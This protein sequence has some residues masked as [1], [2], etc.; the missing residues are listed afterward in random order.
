MVKKWYRSKRVWLITVIAVCITLSLA[1]DLLL[2]RTLKVYVTKALTEQGWRIEKVDLDKQYITLEGLSKEGCFIAKAEIDCHLSLIPF[3]IDP[4]IVF[5]G[6]SIVLQEEADTGFNQMGFILGE[7]IWQPRVWIQ[8]SKIQTAYAECGFEF[9]PGEKKHSI[10]SLFLQEEGQEKPFLQADLHRYDKEITAQLQISEGKLSFL[11]PWIYSF[12]G[13]WELCTGEVSAY[14]Q[15]TWNL[16]SGLSSLQANMSLSHVHLHRTW[17]ECDIQAKMLEGTLS[18]SKQ[19]GVPLWRQADLFITFEEMACTRKDKLGLI[20]GLGEIRLH[21]KEDPYLKVGGTFLTAE[22]YIPFEFE[23]SGELLT[24][25]SYWLQTNL[26]LFLAKGTSQCAS[27]FWQDEQGTATLEVQC[28]KVGKEVS[29]LYQELRHYVNGPQWNIEKGDIEGKILCTFNPSGVTKIEFSDCSAKNI[30]FFMADIDA[31]L[32]A[33]N[34]Q[35]KGLIE[36]VKVSSLQAKV[37][38][39][40]FRY[41]EEELLDL[42][43]QVEIVEGQFMASYLEGLYKEAK[44]AAQVLGAPAENVLHIEC[45]LQGDD[46][47]KW[48]SLEQVNLS[49][50]AP[51]FVVADLYPRE[52]KTD[53]TATI[54]LPTFEDTI[55]DIDV[56]GVFTKKLTRKVED[57]FGSWDFSSIEGQFQMEQ[58][59]SKTVFSLLPAYKLSSPFEASCEVKGLFSPKEVVFNLCALEFSMNYGSYKLLGQMGDREPIT[60][61]YQRGHKHL[62]GKGFIDTLLCQDRSLGIE[63]EIVET[64]FYVA[65]G[66]LW[67]KECLALVEG[68]PV[69]TAFSCDK[70]SFTLYTNAMEI[71]L[72][73]LSPLVEKLYVGIRDLPLEG[74]VFI[75]ERGASLR[76]YKEGDNWKPYWTLAADLFEGSSILG[77]AGN[78][79]EVQAKL[80]FG[81]DQ[82]L[83]LQKI[84]GRY[85]SGGFSC[86]LVLDDIVYSNVDPISIVLK[87]VEGTREA[88]AVVGSITKQNEGFLLKMDPKTHVLGISCQMEPIKLSPSMDIYPINFSCSYHFE[89]LPA[90]LAFVKN[91]G[92]SAPECPKD[93]LSGEAYLR[94]KYDGKRSYLQLESPAFSYEGTNVG[95]LDCQLMHE[96]G[97]WKVYPSQI[98]PYKCS[99][100][101]KQKE[102]QWVVSALSLDLPAGRASAEGKYD[103]KLRKV[104]FPTISFLCTAQGV[105]VA[106]KGGI[107]ALL[108]EEGKLTAEGSL[109]RITAQRNNYCCSAR[110]G[111]KFQFS[112][113]E[114]LYL[115]KSQWTVSDL[116]SKK[117]IAQAT[118]GSLRYKLSDNKVL[119]EEGQIKLSKGVFPM[120]DKEIQL[121]LDAILSSDYKK[122]AAVVKEGKIDP[123]A[124]A[125]D[126]KQVQFLQEKNKLYL[127][128]SGL[129]ETKPI[130]IQW[131]SDTDFCNATV[132]CKEDPQSSGL[133]FRMPKFGQIQEV[134]GSCYGLALKIQKAGVSDKKLDTYNVQCKVDF[135][136]LAPLLPMQMKEMIKKWK[137]GSGYEFSGVVA[138]QAGSLQWNGAKG[139]ITGKEFVCLGRKMDSFS[140]KLS[141]TK[142]VAMLQDL[143]MEDD[144]GCVI[145][146][147]LEARAHPE[148][149]HWRVSAPLIHIKD[150]SPSLL[151]KGVK[152]GPVIKNISVYGLKGLLHDVNSF[153]G[154]G[155]LNFVTTG[156]K[157]EVSFWDIPLN[158]MKDFGLDTSILTPTV[159]EADFILSQG[160]CYFTCLKNMFSEGERSQFDLANPSQDA[161][162]SL[163]GTWHVDLKM[164]QNV[165]W[166]VTEDLILSIRGSLEKPKY[167][168][169][170]RKDNP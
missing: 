169:K 152:G 9:I 141:L 28:E 75:A 46:L 118:F 143:L 158:L 145:V 20:G 72:S 159:G 51:I 98:G 45:G 128:C 42:A 11:Y 78:I 22:G 10:G 140:A 27:S 96:K 44:V 105:D 132:V 38:K 56:Q 124:I 90:Y 127:I 3:V 134:E 70:E 136:E 54:R 40:K 35:W 29:L 84:K 58:L 24:K 50:K 149:R 154:S 57:V 69:K 104:F 65:E 93:L 30:S 156:Q 109:E 119:V 125:I 92:F 137:L 157:K 53:F 164:K 49:S 123:Y 101:A 60:F 77:M 170:F 115:D 66:K 110:K 95:K 122:V 99:F 111:T 148:T 76:I 91:L 17:E 97:F 133:I 146:K 55:Q 64:P 116:S 126:L 79:E 85:R 37:H 61:S 23:G 130:Q 73:S 113:I 62:E 151:M 94:V 135:A 155:A 147:N 80:C 25:N 107:V 1:K 34:I 144:A 6:I 166:K 13:K 86:D 168:F 153:E 2:A 15:G 114:G 5:S 14:L 7:G 142:D 112:S 139:R 26:S 68:I 162:L 41:K 19:E 12:I 117:S 33:Q 81:S 31:K 32:E 138:T 120:Q 108:S 160:R 74:K 59:S 102:D 167:S 129:C 131:Q 48:L 103:P 121:Q 83:T 87:G 18:F 39:G 63:F 100:E 16:D 161:Y 82:P 88:F 21:P 67:S 8:S 165:V 43:A 150:F 52:E 106:G 36:G 4:N 163:D 47:Q 89:Y 71:S